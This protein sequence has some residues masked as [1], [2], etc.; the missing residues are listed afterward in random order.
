MQDISTTQITV[1][2]HM[3]EELTQSLYF[4]FLICIVYVLYRRTMRFTNNQAVLIVISKVTQQGRN[5]SPESRHAG[6]N[7]TEVFHTYN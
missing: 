3:S 6:V 4:F 7:K 2:R 1:A 5:R